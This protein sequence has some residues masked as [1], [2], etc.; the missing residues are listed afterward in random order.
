MPN[1]S[2]FELA[3]LM[4]GAN[5]TKHIPIIFVTATE[6]NRS[7][8][9]KGY[10]SG[11]VDFLYKPLEPHA[12]QSK[13]SVFIDLYRQKR[14]LADQLRTI[15]R[16]QEAQAELLAN[17]LKTLKELEAA[18]SLTRFALDAAQMGEWGLDYVTGDSFR[19]LRHDQCFGYAQLLPTWTYEDKLLHVHPEDRHLLDHA[20]RDSR[21]GKGDVNCECRVVWPD[22]SI[23]WIASRARFELA[24]D[25]SPLRVAGIVWDVTERKKAERALQEAVNVRDEF[26]SI[27][28][29]ELKTP[30]T[31]LKLNSQL[32][33][34][35]LKR[36]DA[37]AFSVPNL[38]K[39]FDSDATQIDRISRLIDDILDFSRISSGEF[40]MKFERCDLREVVSALVEQSE[41]QARAAGCR[42]QLD[43]QEVVAGTWDRFRIAQVVTNLLTNAMRYGA[44]QPIAV[45]VTT[46][47]DLAQI[48]VRDRGRG[49]A[50]ENHERIFRKFERAVSTN[51]VSGL[52][53][54]L[55]IV[56]QILDSHRGSIRVESE[57][58]QGACFIVDLP[59][60]PPAAR[61]T[62]A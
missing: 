24:P 44:G 31:S 61:R 38:S 43:A 5:R 6:R 25:G 52:G 47:P 36:E 11:A 53:L 51:D 10:E 34:R 40:S 14:A 49:V 17:H 60:E 48:T 39:M 8:S 20:F 27:A 35:R 42:I 41:E 28:S 62:E 57:L 21:A 15:G 33:A 1:M 4:R 58:G 54:G 12:V 45:T 19:S 26:M 13:V 16:Q 46:A 29:H 55:Y 56:R 9:F 32:R 18:E 30:L 2:G 23:H 22:Q 3:E 37:A 7:V 59:L 50:S